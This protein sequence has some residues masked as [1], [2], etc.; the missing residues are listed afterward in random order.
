MPARSPV[1]LFILII[2]GPTAPALSSQEQVWLKAITQQDTS[3]LLQLLPHMETVDSSNNEGKTALMV[4]AKTG[5]ADLLEKL[6][7]RG[8]QMDTTNSRGG[9]ALMYAAANNR[10][11]AVKLLLQAGADFDVRAENGWTAL[12]LAAAKGYIA[13]IR[14]LLEANA[15]PNIPDVYGWTPLMR[16]IEHERLEAVKILVRHKTVEINRINTRGQT[17][18]HIATG[19]G[20]CN[21]ARLLIAHGADP[22]QQDFRHTAAFNVQAC[23]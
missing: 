10:Q 22:G 1:L 12:T 21:T 17:A 20:M 5:D 23:E 15:N 2:L 18:L 3:K 6:L 4:A 7:V 16:A 14:Q 9:T 13:I 8:A 19:E 11:E